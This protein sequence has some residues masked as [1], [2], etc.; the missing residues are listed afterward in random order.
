M[1]GTSPF[2]VGSVVQLTSADISFN[3]G[4]TT[5]Q[6]TNLTAVTKITLVANLD[7]I[8]Q[9]SAVSNSDE[10]YVITDTSH[11]LSQE[12]YLH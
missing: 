9:V 8:L 12:M 11:Y 6:I 2:I 3:S 5:V 10:V 7:K 1:M 4:R